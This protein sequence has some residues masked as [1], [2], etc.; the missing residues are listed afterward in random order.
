MF[1]TLTDGFNAAKNRFQGKANLNPENITEALEDVR[2]SLLEADVEYGVTKNFL[3]RVREKAL[4]QEVS[5]KAGTGKDRIRVTPGDHFIKICQD[6]LEA[7][8]GPESFKLEFP[9]NRPGKIMMVGLQGV[10][11][12]TTTGK[13]ANYFKNQAKKTPLGSCRYL[14]TGC[15]R[16]A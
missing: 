10:G 2:K 4:G 3:G 13:L 16:T 9:A 6:E 5:L 12:T 11:K 7:L 1:N 14:P 8:M 15:C